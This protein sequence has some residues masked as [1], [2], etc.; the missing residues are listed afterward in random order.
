MEPI[1]LRGARQN[2]LKGVDL[3]V[4]HGEVLVITGPSGAGKSSLALDTLYAEG[5]RRYVESFSPYARQFLDRSRRPDLEELRAAPPAIAVDRASPARSGRSTIAT[6]TEVAD[7]LKLLF[8]RVAT[9]R[10]ERCGGEV[11]DERPETVVKR[12]IERWTGRKAVVWLPHRCGHD[13]TDLLETRDTMLPLG[14]TRVLAKGIVRELD[15]LKPSDLDDALVDDELR[16]VVD[17][18]VLRPADRARIIEAIE[19]AM[20][21]FTG[22]VG[23]DVGDQTVSRAAPGRRCIECSFAH[24][25]PSPG[26]FSFNSPLGACEA[27]SGFGRI[28]EVDPH[29]IIENSELT[30][31]DDPIRPFR[32][33]SRTYERRELKRLCLR[34]R[35]PTDVPWQDLEPEHRR[36]IWEGEGQGRGKWFGINAWFEWMESRSYKAHVRIQLARYRR[37]VTCPSCSGMRFAPSSLTYRLHGLTIAEFYNLPVV[38]AMQHLAAIPADDSAAS[39]LIDEIRSRLEFLNSVGVG[40]L[41]LDRMTRTL[42]GGEAQRVGLA[43]S[44]GASLAGTLYVVDEPTAGLHPGDVPKLLETMRKLATAGNALVIVDNHSACISSAD[45]LAELGPG[46]G[47]MGGELLYHGQPQGL[48]GVEKSKTASMLLPSER[49]SQY[50]RREPKG[51]ALIAGAAAHNLKNI[52]VSIPIGAL[53]VVTGPSGSGKSTLVDHVLLRGLRRQ[54][55][56]PTDEPGTH[57]ALKGFESLSDVVV[58]DQSP[59]GRTSRGNPGTYVKAWDVLRNRL[60]R[61]PDAKAQGLTASAFS[62]NVDAGRCEVCR[63]DGHEIVE[64]QFLP[65]VSLPCPAC[66]GRRFQDHVLDIRLRGRNVAELLQMTVRSVLELLH[67]D[68]TLARRLQPLADVGLDYLRLGQPLNTLSDGEAQRLKLARAVGSVASQSLIIVD[69]PTVGLHP[70]DVDHLIRLLHHIVEAGSSVLVV[71]HDMSVAAEADWI[72]DLG[73]GAG[74]DG[75]E[76]VVAGQPE[77]VASCRAS[78]TALFLADIIQGRP[79]LVFDDKNRTRKVPSSPKSEAIVVR[80]A[81]EHNLRKVDVEVPRGQLCAVTGPS[82]SGKSSLAFDVIH[83]EG[84]RRYLQSLSP[85][86]RQ[87][88]RQ[89]PRPEVDTVEGI[90]PS[91]AL[92]PRS[93]TSGGATV[94]TLT[95]VGHY[96]RLLYARVG[97][98]YCPTCGVPAKARTAPEI[99]EDLLS[100]L[101]SRSGSIFARV[102]HH[103]KGTHKDAI[104]R[105]DSLGLT[106]VRVD[107][108]ILDVA[109]PPKLSRYKEHTIDLEISPVAIGEPIDE[110]TTAT[111]LQTGKGTLSVL[112]DDGEEVILSVRRSCSKCGRGFSELDPT[113]FSHHSHHAACP[114]CAG[115]GLES[116]MN[117]EAVVDKKKPLLRGGLRLFELPI[118]KRNLGR[119]LRRIKTIPLD[120]TF[121]GLSEA[122]RN[123]FLNGRGRWPGLSKAVE[124]LSNQGVSAAEGML[125]RGPCSE[126]R[127]ERLSEAPRHVVLETSKEGGLTF[128]QVILLSINRAREVFENLTLSDRGSIVGE[129]LRRQIVSRLTFLED[130]GV[131]YLSLDRRAETLSGGETQ[132]VRLAAQLGSGLSGVC[133]VLDEPTIGLHPR[134]TSRLIEM[135]EKLISTGSTVLVVEHDEQTI[136]AATHV[137]DLGPGGGINGGTIVA[138]GS[139][140]E[141][142]RCKDSPTGRALARSNHKIEP[143]RRETESVDRLVLRGASARNLRGIDVDVPLGRLTAVTGVSG[144][145]KSTLVREVLFRALRQALGLVNDSPPGSFEQILGQEYFKRVIEVDQSPIGRTPRSV[146][147]TYIGIWSDLRRLLA[148]T[149]EARSRGYGPERFSFNTTGGRC[150]ACS[151]QGSVKVE[152]SFLP[153]VSAECEAC[154]GTRFDL[155]TREV[156]YRGLSVDRILSLTAEEGSRLFEPLPRIA[157][158]LRMLCELGLGYLKLGQPSNTLSGGEA[159]RLKLTAELKTKSGGQSL[160]L[161]DEPTTGLHA[162]DVDRLIAVL[163]QFVERGDT[164]VVIEHHPA[165]IWASDHVIDLGPEGGDGGGAIVATGSPLT[166]AGHTASHTGAAL[167]ATFGLEG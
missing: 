50:E 58:M 72:I 136:R 25:E 115:T 101:R 131:G 161:L 26:I 120:Q 8:A 55:G 54:R 164:V 38:Q 31:D 137:I 19:S 103:R 67:E 65:D 111:A 60:A 105:A 10:C 20:R 141:I 122:Q 167:R 96:L 139:P 57:R 21:F 154:R 23:V 56:E 73:P 7:Y 97:V 78:R 126:C 89:L 127:G 102:V 77:Q 159:Q 158:A 75:G 5:Q 40:Y 46:A 30:I 100:L 116:S 113:Q 11:A 74:A 32:G 88:L 151:G 145:G 107:G 14:F 28:I 160:Y 110:S 109:K 80:G 98:Q 48:R 64:M 149:P 118:F 92:E 155:V 129:E 69:E 166:I 124:Q 84:Q 37:Y 91:I 29:K 6:R 34:E 47:D 42:S 165:V 66:G 39:M 81:R 135:L 4:W 62:F 63:G 41:S 148:Q 130:T 99:H 24:Q 123:A 85:F 18:V 36:L 142:A 86:V 156:R 12:L 49:S 43:T 44:L 59:L 119:R 76:V 132:R 150:E 114:R 93:S 134:D 94:A 125:Q 117:F 83:A 15:E 1:R 79:A 157:G 146:P 33:K 53:T 71:S 128:G 22:E 35:I 2:N 68:K 17:R 3:D 147:A 153:D 70:T 104:R 162:L 51:W 143:T 121:D 112:F 108:V 52:D 9:A 13:V 95:E 133:Y 82:G 16:I 90:P 144:S 138:T 106:R 140:Q 163:Q 61:L 27:C 45:K 152:M 87:Y